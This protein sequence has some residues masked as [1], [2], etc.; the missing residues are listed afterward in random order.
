M[1]LA[2]GT[3]A[4]RVSALRE[5]VDEV[6]VASGRERGS[7]AILAVTKTQPR[8]AVLAALGAGLRDVG[9]NYVQEARAKFAGLPPCTKHFVGHVQT[10]KAKAIAGLFDVVQSVDRLEAGLALAKAT[11]DAGRPL[12]VLVQVNVSPT[13]RFGAA[14]ADAPALAARLRAEGLDVDGVMAIGPL[15]GDVDAAFAAARSAFERVGGATLSLGMTDDWERAV[16]HGSTMVRLGTAIF[17]P[18]PAKERS[19]T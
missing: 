17:G 18:R 3:V 12:R 5:R 9:E 4:E 10:N 19:L 13:E 2:G 11:R 6:T 14:P 16:R 8:E 7:V 15:E 1:H